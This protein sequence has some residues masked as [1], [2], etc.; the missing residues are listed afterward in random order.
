MTFACNSLLGCRTVRG[1]LCCVGSDLPATRKLC[2]FL[3]HSANLGCSKCLKSFA[4]SS[5]EKLDYSGF[6]YESWEVRKLEDHRKNVDAVLSAVTATSRA[7][8]EKQYGLRFSVLLNLPVFDVVR[9]HTI[10]PMHKRALQ[11]FV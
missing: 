8:L 1:L 4:S 11:N 7:S 3:S 5:G 2:G 10:D 6:N 9:F